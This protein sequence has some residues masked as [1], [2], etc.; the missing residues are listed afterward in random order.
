MIKLE[1]LLIHNMLFKPTQVQ[2]KI[3][4][5]KLLMQSVKI[6]Q[7]INL[8]N[9]NSLQIQNLIHWKNKNLLFRIK[10][11]IQLN[12]FSESKMSK[13][14]KLIWEALSIGSK[15]SATPPHQ[16]LIIILK[17]NQKTVQLSRS[18]SIVCLMKTNI[19]IIIL[20]II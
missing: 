13:K 6:Y 2:L 12:Y 17:W 4:R 18:I 8:D 20:V 5:D 9:N 16:L 11:K 10:T 7:L 1:H 19:L 15:L 3:N 14:Q